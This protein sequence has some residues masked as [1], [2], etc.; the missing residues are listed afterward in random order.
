M[1]LFSLLV[2]ATGLFG[3]APGPGKERKAHPAGKEDSFLLHSDVERQVSYRIP[4][5][6]KAGYSDLGYLR[7][8]RI[9]R[10]KASIHV[11]VRLRDREHLIK[12]NRWKSWYMRNTGRLQ[13]TVVDRGS[14]VP[15]RESGDRLIII[16]YRNKRGTWLE[17]IKITFRGET[18][19]VVT[20]RAP[21]G[22]FKDISDTCDAVMG[23]VRF[24][25]L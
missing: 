22:S 23:S 2:S 18:M 8:H 6:W 20:C 13:V 19:V 4:T 14:L 21:L 12:W 11:Y 7:L 24:S 10:G 5:D 25:V 17:R 16:Q 15:E 3:G 9:S 1:A